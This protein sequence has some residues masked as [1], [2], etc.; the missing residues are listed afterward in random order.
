MRSG[1][2]DSPLFTAVLWIGGA[3]ALGACTADHEPGETAAKA[4]PPG[5]IRVRLAP[6]CRRG[7]SVLA[8]G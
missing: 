7:L 1:V 4:C 2:T 8:T 5:P 6:A 3:L